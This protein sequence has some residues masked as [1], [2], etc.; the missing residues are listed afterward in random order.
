MKLSSKAIEKRRR[1]LE[2]KR[3]ALKENHL[4]AI[5]NLLP[6]ELIEDACVQDNYVYRKTLLNPIT[7]VLHLLT[8]ALSPEASFKSAMD[9]VTDNAYSGSFSKAR[10]R[11]PLSIL[12][13]IHAHIVGLNN[14]YEKTWHGYHVVIP[15]GTCVSMPDTPE[16][17]NTFGRGGAKTMQSR[18]PIAR[19]NYVISLSTLMPIAYELDQYRI[20]ELTLFKRILGNL[21]QKSLIVADRFYGGAHWYVT[22]K[23]HGCD[24]LT[25]AHQRLNVSKLAVVHEYNKDDKLVQLTI[26]KPYQRKDKTAP[27][28]IVVRAIQ[29]TMTIR[30]KEETFWIMTSLLNKKYTVKDLKALY[31]T[32]WKVEEL[33]YE[34]KVQLHADVLRSQTA[35][36]IRK[37]FCAR[38]LAQSILHLLMVQA[39]KK[40]G[41]RHDKIS[42][43]TSKRIVLKY[44]YLM[45]ASP[46]QRLPRIFTQMLKTIAKA[47]T[48]DRPDRI[49]P[50]KVKREQKHYQ[51]L[52]IPRQQWHQQNLLIA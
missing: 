24:F 31:R 23:R 50:R 45:S 14:Q 4:V 34:L 52:R 33:L 12:Q 47:V 37:E 9:M 44:S 26:G 30:G 16:L 43:V 15:D 17:V 3:E 25:R 46:T 38:L 28:S 22:Y 41:Q 20:S 48:P 19:C 13:T 29:V 49:E 7:T 35:Q 42:F 21:K 27:K 39:A 8:A 6:D 18:F 2:Q 51:F 36:N 5:R 40:H 1:K 10:S 11:L 32:R